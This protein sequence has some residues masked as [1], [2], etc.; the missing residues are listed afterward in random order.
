MVFSLLK[1]YKEVL[2][3]LLFGVL[4]TIINIVVFE[5]CM[6]RVH[7][8]LSLAN[9]AAWVLS[10]LFAFITNKLFVFDSTG[11]HLVKELLLF[12][13]ARVVTLVLET[14]ALMVM[15][16]QLHI[17]SLFAKMIS[18]VFVIILNYIFSKFVIF[19]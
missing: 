12:F 5:F 7:L 1:K 18:N 4:T 14:L 15:I 16:D 11:T 6:N 9:G 3:Y 8:P 17:N 10:V 2:L 13:S 19:K